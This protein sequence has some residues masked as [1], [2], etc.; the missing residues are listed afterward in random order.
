MS[1]TVVTELPTA[2]AIPLA[3][4]HA[5]CFPEEP[6]NAAVMDRLRALG[7]FGRLAWQDKEPIGFVL[8]RDLGDE[9]EVLSLG[10]L[11]AA[12]RRGVGRALLAAVVAEA[13]R[14]GL[15]S[16]VLEVAAANTPARRLYAGAGFVQVGRRPGYYR[17][18]GEGGDG[19]ILR[20]AI[21]G[22]V[23]SA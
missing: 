6:W 23:A 3:A 17:H 20:R 14:R 12:R 5:V 22:A 4:M 10:V 19:L 8:V 1:A 9:A 13:E 11:P 15:A 18:L 7:V 21:T 2:A 16:V